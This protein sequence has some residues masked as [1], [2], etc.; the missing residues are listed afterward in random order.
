MIRG[1][2]RGVVMG[3]KQVPLAVVLV[4]LLG[5]GLLVP[6]PVEPTLSTELLFAAEVETRLEDE[7]SSKL[8]GQL[9]LRINHDDGEWLTSNLSR[10]QS[11]LQLEQEAIDGSNPD[12]SWDVEGIRFGRIESP[13]SSWSDA[14]AS[15]NR[16]L[17]NATRWADVLQP[18]LENGWC[19]NSSTDEENEA[20]QATMLLLPDGSNYGVACPDFSG[21][22]ATQPPQAKEVIW[23]VWF[24]SDHP[25]PDWNLLNDWAQKISDSTE[26]EVSAVG[27]NMMFAK[28]RN[29][30][31]EDMA[32]V[33]FPAF[34]VLAL[35]LAVGLR[36][37]RGAAATLGGA[38]LVIGAELGLLS[39]LGY[40]FSIIDMIAFPIILGVAVDGAFW[41]CKSSRDR[42]EV[43]K[44]LFVAMVTTIAAI[45]L[46]LLS[47]VRAQRSLSFVMIIGIALS[48]VF[49]R[50][51]LEDFYLKRRSKINATIE[52]E[53]IQPHRKLAWSWPIALILLTSVAVIAP[54][55][56]NVLD[57]HQFLPEGDPSIGEMED[58]Q[59]KYILASSTIAW[60]L[61]DADGDS[62]EDLL[63]IVV[64]QEQISLHPSV[65]SV[66]TG[67]IRFPMILG[68]P[69]YDNE[70]SGETIDSVFASSDGSILIADS[71][72]QRDGVTT[73][74]AIGVL[75]DGSNAEAALIFAEDV[76][77]LLEENDLSGIAGG[78]LPTGAALAHAFEESRITQILAAG[79]GI[80]VVSYFVLRSPRR[81]ARIAIGTI[82]IGIAVD[83]IASLMDG[84][85][86]ST[87]PAVLLGMGFTA[88]YLS[89]ASSEHPPTRRDNSARWWAAATSCSVFVMLAMATFP[90]THSTG[91]LLSISILLSVI[92]ATCLSLNHLPSHRSESEE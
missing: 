44:M 33:L 38:A 48:W 18:T 26:F 49:T 73:G 12:T 40:T 69:S 27:L 5:C 53:I 47:P 8:T 57:V 7:S 22:S 89:H 13:F 21:A 52:S 85:D 61:V 88:D 14:F 86:N 83:G 68:I 50:Y 36:D 45:S 25:N 63:Q 17:T 39:A 91:K 20:L 4:L 32:K 67:L 54:P 3:P 1:R 55:G 29:I 60:V 28:S 81:A 37:I 71:R 79:L 66:D 30:A 62:P 6:F 84:R 72:L 74:V 31:E 24:E 64:L 90:P 46:A 78:D 59:S 23:L 42:D 2:Q 10:V 87:A 9:V 19:G 80:F 11:L 92:L 56:V 41:Y 51:V 43:R 70:N 15:R 76:E 58:L 77:A 82:A 75:I 34:V 16:S 35:I 65:V